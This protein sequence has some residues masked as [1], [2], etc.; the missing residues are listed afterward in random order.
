LA[1][2]IEPSS[3]LL[4]RA[5]PIV[6]ERLSDMAQL[7]AQTQLNQK[8]EFDNQKKEFE[9]LDESVKQNAN[10]II[11]RVAGCFAAISKGL[12]TESDS[13]LPPETVDSGVVENVQ[14][15]MPLPLTLPLALATTQVSTFKMNRKITTIKDAWEEYDSGIAYP[16]S[17]KLAVRDLE[18]LH[19]TKWRSNPTDMKFFQRRNILYQFIMRLSDLHPNLEELLIT[20]DQMRGEKSL[21]K[22]VADLNA[23]KKA[24]P[25]NYV[26][27]WYQNHYEPF[28]AL[29]ALQ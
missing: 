16:G 10:M 23:Y 25:E 17:V 4:D 14:L 21:S 28:V 15:Q 7:I 13:E 12:S 19:G 9:R 3:I 27:D 29:Q 5:L 18:L 1:A 2:E 22:Y 24:N 20:M 11:K 6:T 8:K 26:A